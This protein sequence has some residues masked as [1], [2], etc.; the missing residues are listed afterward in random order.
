MSQTAERRSVSDRLNHEKIASSPAVAD[1]ADTNADS[2]TTDSE[3]D[4]EIES[5]RRRRPNTP[6]PVIT[7]P[8]KVSGTRFEKLNVPAA[9]AGLSSSSANRWPN[10]AT[11]PVAPARSAQSDRSAQPRNETTRKPSAPANQA[12]RAP[13]TARGLGSF[14]KVAKNNNAGDTPENDDA[15]RDSTQ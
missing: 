11:Q 6:P 9:N 4:Q 14:V 1:P 2:Q 8:T 10:E 5:Y 12:P 13:I 15:P 7:T 3:M